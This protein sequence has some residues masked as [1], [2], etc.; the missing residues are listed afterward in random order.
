[1]SEPKI[2]YYWKFGDGHTSTE[3]SP[4]HI[5]EKPGKYTVE[6]TVN[7]SDFGEITTT[8]VSYIIVTPALGNYPYKSNK[9]FSFGFVG[10]N[11]QDSKIVNPEDYLKKQDNTLQ[12]SVFE[13]LTGSINVTK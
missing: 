1:M 8:K 4:E 11:L 5:Y 6:L 3:V 12:S 9:S 10:L 13:E 2:T 7:I